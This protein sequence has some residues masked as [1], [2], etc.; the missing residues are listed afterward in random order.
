MKQPA[1]ANSDGL[2]R[3]FFKVDEGIHLVRLVHV[4]MDLHSRSE[5]ESESESESC[6]ERTHEGYACFERSKT[7]DQAAGWA[8]SQQECH[9]ARS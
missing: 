4:G 8:L 2:C 1:T 7:G 6:R 5:S 3:R 9:C